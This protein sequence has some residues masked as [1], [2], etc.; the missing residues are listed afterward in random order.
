MA[1]QSTPQAMQSRPGSRSGGSLGA[2]DR[3]IHLPKMPAGRDYDDDGEP[4]DLDWVERVRTL[5]PTCSPSKQNSMPL[6]PGL[7]LVGTTRLSSKQKTV[8]ST[9]WSPLN[10]GNT[11][12]P[13][14]SVRG[15]SKQAPTESSQAMDRLSDSLRGA[16]PD[17]LGVSSLEGWGRP[18]E[19]EGWERG[20]PS[21]QSVA[22][23]WAIPFEDLKDARDLFCEYAQCSPSNRQNILR[24]GRISVDDFYKVLCKVSD[25]AGVEDLPEGMMHDSFE[26]VDENKDGWINF[27]EFAIWHETMAFA[28]SV[29]LSKDERQS[30]DVARQMGISIGA[31]DQY[32]RLFKKFDANNS[33]LIEFNEFSGLMHVLM[34][35][36]GELQIPESR[37]RHFFREA[38]L[39]GNGELDLQ[40]FVAFYGKHFDVNSPDPMETFYKG[41]RNVVAA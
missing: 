37:I 30:R 13:T 16:P 23:S 24:D 6:L 31:M 9:D 22:S 34:K 2:L 10:R 12:T 7:E 36:K 19:M 33:G 11:R 15:V 28:E 8:S 27:W 14:E 1:R 35:T 32:T 38:D 17:S 18:L 39:N 5:R 3:S 41:F 4:I 21:L 25:S 26:H 40:E 29:V 20:V